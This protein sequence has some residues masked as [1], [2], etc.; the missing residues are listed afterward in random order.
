MEV[1]TLFTY[2]GGVCNYKTRPKEFVDKI[3][4]YNVVEWIV[5][6]VEEE[7]GVVITKTTLLLN[8]RDT[9]K[10][11]LLD[12]SKDIHPSIYIGSEGGQSHDIY[13]WNGIVRFLLS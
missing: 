2:N 8:N 10:S 11:F 5:K 13:L 1:I 12:R 7:D 3:K 9:G 6:D 4:C